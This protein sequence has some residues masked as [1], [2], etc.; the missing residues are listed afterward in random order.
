MRYMKL[1][2]CAR[3]YFERTW[4]R[5]PRFVPL[6]IEHKLR[7]YQAYESAVVGLLWTC[8]FPLEWDGPF[9]LFGQEMALLLDLR[10]EFKLRSQ[11][12]FPPSQ[13]SINAPSISCLLQT[14]HSVKG[15]IKGLCYYALLDYTGKTCGFKVCCWCSTHWLYVGMYTSLSREI[16]AS[17]IRRSFRRWYLQSTVWLEMISSVTILLTI[18]TVGRP[19]CMLLSVFLSACSLLYTDTPHVCPVG[20]RALSLLSCGAECVSCHCRSTAVPLNT[21]RCSTLCSVW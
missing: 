10:K 19:F 11:L 2:G 7:G 9:C 16:S 14:L 18:R 5:V 1:K 21:Q 4:H 3:Q 6:K 13:A 15:C 12:H 20:Y 17:P 8:L